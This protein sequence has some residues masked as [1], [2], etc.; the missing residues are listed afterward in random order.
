MPIALENRTFGIE[1][2]I[3]LPTGTMEVGQYHSP[4]QIEG[5]PAGWGAQ[6][7][8]S[9]SAPGHRM[10]V[11]VVSPI[12][13]GADGMRQVVEV[14]RKLNAMGGKVNASCGFHVHIGIDDSELPKLAQVVHLFA[15]TEKGFYASTGTRNR[16]HNSYCRSIKGPNSQHERYN[17]DAAGTTGR[18]AS[19]GSRPERFHTLNLVPLFTGQRKAMEFRVFQGTLSIEKICGYIRMCIGVVDKGVNM[20]RRCGWNARGRGGVGGEQGTPLNGREELNRLFYRLGWNRGA[21]PEVYGALADRVDGIPTLAECM[22][23]L[24]AMATKYDQAVTAAAVA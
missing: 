4:R 6:R 3:T 20:Q 21:C 7:D 23:K 2:E 24:M 18:V 8:G 5:F 15:N 1:L 14:V 9:I 19:I 13:R 17:Y 11:E 16:E 10:G 12:L 22:V